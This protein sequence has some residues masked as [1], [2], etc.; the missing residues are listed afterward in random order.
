VVGIDDEVGANGTVQFEV[1]T[2]ST[3][4]YQSPVVTGNDTGL[5]VDLDVTGRGT[6]R[7]LVTIGPDNAFYDHGDWGDAKLTCNS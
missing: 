1:W 3:R 6:L 2:G 5:T 4:L 7:F